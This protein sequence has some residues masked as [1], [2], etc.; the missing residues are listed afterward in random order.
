[1]PRRLGVVMSGIPGDRI[2]AESSLVAWR[3]TGIGAGI[4]SLALLG[5]WLMAGR[6]LRPI[7]EMGAAARTIAEGHLSERLPVPSEENELSELAC[8]LNSSFNR[9]EGLLQQQ[10]R[11]TADASHELRT[12]LAVISTEAEAAL[13]DEPMSESVASSFKLCLNST[14]HMRDLVASMLDLARLDAGEATLNVESQDL[15]PLIEKTVELLQP[16]AK[17][18]GARFSV[19]ARPVACLIDA[20]KVRQV[21]VNLVSNAIKHT[22]SRG[23]ISISLDERDGEAVIEV[24]DTGEGIAPEDLAHVFDRF[25]RADRARSS[26]SDGIGLG[27]SITKGIVD[28]HGGTIEVSSEIGQGTTVMVKLRC[29]EVAA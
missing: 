25:Y 7:E 24:T 6:A 5:G 21:M 18:K 4:C 29:V 1:M 26:R 13:L 12:P 3:L 10:A 14:R 15:A 27:L 2:R 16:L 22:P 11:F 8:V 23:T 17:E 28:A 20:E 9:L 19:T